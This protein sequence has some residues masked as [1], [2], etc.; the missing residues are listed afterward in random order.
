MTVN[1]VKSIEN[2][3]FKL[4]NNVIALHGEDK[5][6]KVEL[7]SGEI[8]EADGI[9]IAIGNSPETELVKGQIE[10]TDGGFIVTDSNLKTNLNLVYAAGDVT[11]KKLRQ[12]VTAQSDGALAVTSILEEL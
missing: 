11:D 8:I 2:I 4:N 5:L 9:F 7:K 3:E 1:K 12:I 10:L 6:T